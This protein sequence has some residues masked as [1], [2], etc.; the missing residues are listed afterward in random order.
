MIELKNKVIRGELGDIL[1]VNT[2]INW[3]RDANYYEKNKWRGT[4]ALDG[5]AALMNQ[6]IH[7]LDLL[8][9]LMGEIFQVSAQIETKQ[10]II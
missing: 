7:T 5:G 4:L 1:I 10:H 3:Y 2:E 9:D 8:I 6:G